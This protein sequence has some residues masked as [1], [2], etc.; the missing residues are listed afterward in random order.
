LGSLAKEVEALL[1]SFGFCGKTF[2]KEKRLLFQ[3]VLNFTQLIIHYLAS[4]M[5]LEML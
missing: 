3:P 4:S 5:N 1:L 2:L